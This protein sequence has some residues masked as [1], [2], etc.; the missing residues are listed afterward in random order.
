MTASLPSLSL[1][2]SSSHECVAV[3]PIILDEFDKTDKIKNISKIRRNIS[4]SVS[5]MKRS[6]V[7]K[8]SN[9]SQVSTLNEGSNHSTIS[10]DETSVSKDDSS[11]E[12][13]IDSLKTL[14]SCL[15]GNRQKTN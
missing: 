9:L 13:G 3:S 15:K 5:F 11:E 6:L 2:R 7:R 12:V 10:L 14:R 4:R 8:N 1:L